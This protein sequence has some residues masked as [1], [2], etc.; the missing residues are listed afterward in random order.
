M[1]PIVQRAISA[2][3]C[4]SLFGGW[5][6]PSP[7]PVQPPDPI[8]KKIECMTL[9]EEVGQL[10][11]VRPQALDTAHTQSYTSVTEQG[12][13]FLAQYPVGGVI[14]FKDNLIDP[15]QLE[16]FLTGL[17]QA[18]ELPLLVAVDEEGGTVTRVASNPSFGV[19]RYPSAAVVAASGDP[20]DVRTMSR[21][22]GGYLKR[23][24]FTLDFAPV[25][26]V[27]TNP[28]NPIIGKRVL[29]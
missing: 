11:M 9:R 10:F 2:V 28:R 16:R 14:L 18:S 4:L 24:G 20:E 3:L 13:E 29:I 8:A 1:L 19:E 27:N 12:R 6:P 25:T 15:D 22:I 23:F 7:M 5:M 21:N 26:D 17:Q